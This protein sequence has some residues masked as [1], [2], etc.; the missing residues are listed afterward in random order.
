[1]DWKYKHF[2]QERVFPA[3]RE[4]VFEAARTFMGESLG[5]KITDTPE[6]TRL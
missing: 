2:H 6:G 3:E 1:M 4:L 5:W